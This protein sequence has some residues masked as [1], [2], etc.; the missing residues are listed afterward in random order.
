MSL[1]PRKIWRNYPPFFNTSQE[2]GELY[3]LTEAL[4]QAIEEA[5]LDAEAGKKMMVLLTA[6]G[7]WVDRWGSYFGV[8]RLDGEDDETYKKR[9]IW[10]VVRPKQTLQGIKECIA[11]YTGLSEDEVIL[12][13]PFIKLRPTDFGATTDT[14]RL[15]GW[16]YWTWAVIDIRVPI[17]IDADLAR[18]IQ[19]TTKAYGVKIFITTQSDDLIT[20]DPLSIVGETLSISNIHFDIIEVITITD[21]LG[22]TDGR[23]LVKD[24]NNSLYEYILSYTTDW[25]EYGFGEGGFGDVPFGGR[26]IIYESIVYVG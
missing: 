10:E 7:K 1:L 17:Q 20:F 18:R 21:T 12:F 24:E 15:A 8:E 3:T 6:E 23:L 16:E 11:H 14:T 22:L 9:I 5:G 26:G 19:D 2:E 4:R 25:G 13:E